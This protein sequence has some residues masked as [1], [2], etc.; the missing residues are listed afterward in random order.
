MTT[1]FRRHSLLVVAAAGLLLCAALA[2]SVAPAAA[3]STVAQ[4]MSGLDNPRGLA[5][6]PQGALYVAEA[7]K[8]PSDPS[9]F[10]HSASCICFQAGQLVCY[11]PT[12]AVSRL[13]HGRQERVATG[14]PSYANAAGRAEG[15]ND[16]AMLGVGTARVTIGLE[17]SPILRDQLGEVQPEWAGFGR[18]VQVAASGEWRFVADLAAYER[19]FNPDQDH[20][21]VADSNP[22]GVLALPGADLVTDAGGNDV[23]RVDAN[24]EISLV[25]VLPV[26]PQ[27]T[28][29]DPVPTTIALGPDGAYYVGELTGAPFRDGAASIYRIE[30]GQE[31]SLFLT[32]FKSII[33][34]AFDKA[35]NLY[36]LQHSTGPTMLTAPGTLIRVDPDGNRTTIIDPQTQLPDGTIGLKRPTSVAVGPDG[37]VYVTNNG[38][39]PWSGEV[40]RIE[41]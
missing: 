4:V 36:V 34:V 39:S 37:A 6:G 1:R 8:G 11:G 32:G 22:F 12:G 33:D 25:A 14:L 30:P 26:V 15:P 23:V 40:L 7:G 24:G 19:D 10:A 41:P 21:P 38:L 31:P 20:R 3:V 35:G 9:C 18:L 16:I 2:G 5:F 13:W 17:A 27:A 28:D 29:G